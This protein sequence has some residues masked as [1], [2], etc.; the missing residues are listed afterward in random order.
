MEGK[1]EKTISLKI[2]EELL[3]DI[4]RI[5]AENDRT[6]SSMI[7]VILAEYARKKTYNN[8]SEDKR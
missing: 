3:G 2:G 7:R 4:S 5:A 6:L 1:R 8:D